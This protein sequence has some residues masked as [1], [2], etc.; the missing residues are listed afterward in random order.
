MRTGLESTLLGIERGGMTEPRPLL[1][2]TTFNF[3][4]LLMLPRINMSELYL[5]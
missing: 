1:S 5:T 3:L 2:M 4:T